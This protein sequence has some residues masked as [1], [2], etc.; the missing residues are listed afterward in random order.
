MDNENEFTKRFVDDI[1]K[2]IND[3][4]DSNS[5]E[6]ELDEFINKITAN[7]NSNTKKTVELIKNIE[8]IKRKQK[9]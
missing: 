8:V 5:D 7:V 6:Q 9:I 1:K 3:Q 2:A 4:L